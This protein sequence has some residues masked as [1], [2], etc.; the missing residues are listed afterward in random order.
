MLSFPPFRLDLES[1]RLWRGDQ[2]LH[3]RRK[4]F[5][6]LRYLVQNPNRL[7]SHEEIVAA[8]WGKIAMSESLLRTHVRDLRQAM[9]ENVVETVVGRGY[10]FAADVGHVPVEMVH[11]GHEE[12]CR[13]IVVGRDTELAT[14]R[15][16]FRGASEQ[17]RTTVFVT[18]EAG[19][20][21]TTL[22]DHFVEQT[23]LRMPILVGRGACV[24]H[25]GEGQA[26]LPL[27]E[28]VGALCRG[29]NGNRVAD[30]LARLAPTWLSQMPGVVA[31]D[32]LEELQHRAAGAAQ[33]RMLRELAEAL[34][35]LSAQA[36]VVLVLEDMH[37]ADASTVEA[38]ALL[39]RRREAVR[40]LVLATYRPA[41]V[42]RGDP[43]SRV[44]G[45]LVSH[46]QANA[47]ELE[48]FD[49]EDVDAYL[50]ARFPGH[51]FSPELASTLLQ[52]TGGNPL[53]VA[54]LADDLE[55]RGLI[56]RRDDV[57]QLTTSVEDVAARRPDGIVRLIDTQL[58]RLGAIEQR[59]I[60]AASL[61]GMTFTAGVVASALAE[62]PDVIDSYCE[63]LAHDRKLLRHIGAETTPDGTVQARY[64][65][66]HE[67]FR[68][69]ALERTSL[70]NARTWKRRIAEVAS[71]E[72]EAAPDS[73]V[74]TPARVASRWPSPSDA[75]RFAASTP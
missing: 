8:V 29:R 75:P 64:A 65:F 58:D 49:A 60:E 53:F 16:A 61:A 25:E 3:V 55:T 31:N 23:S 36:P 6:I 21:K 62:D 2:E 33:A 15:S 37:W 67:L 72:R 74:V 30:V 45:E 20:G 10:R 18:G 12:A 32:R 14:L 50:N 52:S 24:E 9:G 17:R 63:S 56:A 66:G 28:A 35:A 41:E 40:C 44:V 19:V 7:V 51:R 59:I 68:H 54:T 48:G 38:L 22:V 43:L 69:A 39:S 46:R 27:L 26:C 4:P 47:M 13:R 11:D 57:W 71:P 34:E 70:V 5:A 42:V 73:E 1:E